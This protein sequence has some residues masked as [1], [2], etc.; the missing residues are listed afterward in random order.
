M[1]PKA[2]FLPVVGR[3]FA[4]IPAGPEGFHT[5]RFFLTSTRRA[6]DVGDNAISKPRLIRDIF[7]AG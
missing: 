2:G 5:S 4:V 7:E 1:I 3:P 6:P